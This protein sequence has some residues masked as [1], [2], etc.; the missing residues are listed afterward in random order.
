[1][2]G[3]VLF[4]TALTSVILTLI[5]AGNAAEEWMVAKTPKGVCNVQLKTAALLG[6]E[7]FKGPFST[8]GA[9][10]A[11]ASKQYDPD[12]KDPSKCTAY[13]VGSIAGCAIDQIPLPPKS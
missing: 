3:S 1:M 13:E 2:R 4:F 12:L 6:S 11:E 9:A 5:T 8:R 10:C 7:P